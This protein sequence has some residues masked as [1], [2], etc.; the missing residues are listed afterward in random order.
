MILRFYKDLKPPYFWWYGNTRE[1]VLMTKEESPNY[2]SIDIAT[3][4][5]EKGCYFPNLSAFKRYCT[6]EKFP[7]K[8][9]KEWLDYLDNTI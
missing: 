9:K 6:D 2:L 8:I 5:E 1:F 4:L 7:L 3:G